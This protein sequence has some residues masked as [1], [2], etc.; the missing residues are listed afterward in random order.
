MPKFKAW[1]AAARLRTLPLSVSGIIVGSSSAKDHP[2]FQ[3]DIFLLA[4]LTT[5]GFQVLSNFANDYGDGIKGV[6]DD[7]EGE[8][9][10]VASGLISAKQIKLGIIITASVTLFI[11]VNLI[12]AA[13]G[14]ED[15]FNFLL[16]LVLGIISIVAALKYTIGKNAY[17]YSGLGDVFVFLFFGLLSVLGSNYLFTHELKW[18]LLLPASS[19]GMLSMAVLNLNNMRDIEN[20]KKNKKNTLVVSLG[21]SKAKIYH[22]IL[23]SIGMALTLLY[24]V[25]NYHSISQFTY[26]ITFIP[27]W[28]N[29]VTVYKNKEPKLLDNELKKVAL[30]TF[31]FAILFGFFH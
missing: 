11:A 30:S 25:I 27:L 28:M 17:G 2:L 29:L 18:D 22:Y 13:F 12:Y 6:D 15:F 10:M 1:V 20:D 24:S 23:I 21:S 3:T 7:R 26:S 4:I 31:L 14:W 9:R 5:I 16:F 19:I 8:K